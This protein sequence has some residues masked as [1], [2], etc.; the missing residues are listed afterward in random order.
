MKLQDDL[1]GNVKQAFKNHLN[2]LDTVVKYV[3][4]QL[5]VG[6]AERE[7]LYTELDAT[8]KENDE[9]FNN[10]LLSATRSM[11]EMSVMVDEQMRL[12]LWAINPNTAVNKE[13][14]MVQ[15]AL[16]A[17]KTIDVIRSSITKTEVH[18]HIYIIYICV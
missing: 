3:I 8:S 11:S 14:I 15:Y 17:N 5:A 18:T 10:Q 12:G 4:T 9:I 16:T 7:R 1:S 2:R 6:H 13:Q